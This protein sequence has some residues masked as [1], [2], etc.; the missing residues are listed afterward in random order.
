MTQLVPLRDIAYL[1]PGVSPTL[2]E[3][4]NTTVSFLPMSAVNEDG[5]LVAPE[6]RPAAAVI[7]GYTAFQRGDVLLAK[8]TPCMENGK[9]AY[10]LDLPHEHGFGSTEF[11]VLRPK[12]NVDGRFLFYLIWNSNFRFVAKKNMTGSAGQKR[13]PVSFLNELNVLLPPKLEEQ[14]RIAAILD[15]ANAIRRKRRQAAELADEF[16]RSVFLDMFGDPVLNPN[17]YPM[18]KF[19][20]GSVGKLER[21]KSTHRPRNDP[22]LLGGPYPFIQTGDVANSKGYIRTWNRAYS[23]LGLKQS[24]M[25]SEGTLCITIAANIAKTGILKFDACFPDSIVGFT[26]AAKITAEYVQFWMSFLQ[27]TLEAQ[28]PESAQKNINLEI[29]R[30]LEILIP[31]PRLINSFTLIVQKVEAYIDTLA[32]NATYAE[33]LASSLAANFFDLR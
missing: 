4:P 9:A 29:L 15:K 32:K 31:E 21:G 27:K 2:K 6:E 5:C 20:D 33:N 12:E 16:L 1:N 7:R 18:K 24:R 22:D 28:A 30:N 19:G 3:R 26:P 17:Q 11:H 10:L 25:W 23:E 8:I 14:K 13:V